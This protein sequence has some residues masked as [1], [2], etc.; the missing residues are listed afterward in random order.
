MPQQVKLP[1]TLIA[2]LSGLPESGMG[3]QLVDI[4]L[5]DGR[6]LSRRKVLNAEFLLLEET[7]NIHTEDVTGVMLSQRSSS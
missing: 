3:Y 1:E 2:I 6:T 5:K 4:T 7:E